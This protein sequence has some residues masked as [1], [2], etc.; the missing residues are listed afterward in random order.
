MSESPQPGNPLYFL[1]QLGLADERMRFTC[2]V[3]QEG[4]RGSLIAENA[5]GSHSRM[6]EFCREI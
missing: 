1:T 4:W 2:C 5:A 3:P 6:V